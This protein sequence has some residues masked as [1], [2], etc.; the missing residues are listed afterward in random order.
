[1]VNRRLRFVAFVDFNPDVA[2]ISQALLRILREAAPQQPPNP[3]G[4]AAGRADQSG[5]RSRILPI[6]SD[7]VSPPKARRPVNIS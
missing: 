1:M 2:D 3:S 5:S 4:V 7:A 6:V